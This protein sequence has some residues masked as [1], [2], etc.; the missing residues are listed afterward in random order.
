[1]DREILVNAFRKALNGEDVT[2][3]ELGLIKEFLLNRYLFS[4]AGEIMCD[5]ITGCDC[6]D[7][8]QL[9]IECLLHEIDNTILLRF[10]K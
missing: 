10:G 4:N 9:I 1:M 2:A 8:K 5:T 7:A 6:Q 3:E